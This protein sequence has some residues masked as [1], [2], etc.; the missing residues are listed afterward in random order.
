MRGYE[1]LEVDKFRRRV[2]RMSRHPVVDWKR[3]SQDA[4]LQEMQN[5]R[6]LL[7]AA[8]MVQR[9]CAEPDLDRR[10]VNAAAVHIATAIG[11]IRLRTRGMPNTGIYGV[12]AGDIQKHMVRISKDIV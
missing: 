4:T 7:V 1:S 8:E 3:L 6:D 12:I 9:I 10:T 5:I 2:R 11:I